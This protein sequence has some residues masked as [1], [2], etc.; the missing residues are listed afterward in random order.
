[1]SII[2]KEVPEP[3]RISLQVCNCNLIPDLAYSWSHWVAV[4]TVNLIE[5]DLEADIL[6]YDSNINPQIKLLLSELVHT[7]RPTFTV[8]KEMV[9]TVAESEVLE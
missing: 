2:Q 7:S 1:M 5:A 9:A 6:L 4:S 3:N 8:G